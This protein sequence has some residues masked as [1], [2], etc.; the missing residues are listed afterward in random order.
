V[1]V[2]HDAVNQEALATLDAS[3]GDPDG[4]EQDNVCFNF[5]RLTADD[6]AVLSV[7]ELPPGS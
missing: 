6:M 3:L 2:S 5:L 4:I 1:V 7:N